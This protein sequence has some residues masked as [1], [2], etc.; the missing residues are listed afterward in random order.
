[1]NKLIKI[2]SQFTMKWWDD[3]EKFVVNSEND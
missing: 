2:N 1:M 3:Y